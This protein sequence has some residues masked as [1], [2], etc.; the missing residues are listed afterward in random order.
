MIGVLSLGLG[1]FFGGFVL[2]QRMKAVFF[3]HA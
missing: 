2:F 1:T 3:D